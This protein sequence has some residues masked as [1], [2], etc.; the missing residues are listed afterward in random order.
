MLHS[1]G[2]QVGFHVHV[3][4]ILTGGGLSLDKDAGQQRW[5]EIPRDHPALQAE[6]LSVIF[7]RL[8]LRRLKEAL[9]R[10]K[11]QWPE[12]LLAGVVLPVANKSD[13][14]IHNISTDADID[15]ATEEPSPP[16]KKQTLRV[17]T[18]DELDLL[19][20]LGR[21]AYSQHRAASRI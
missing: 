18:A 12:T 2:Q 3:H 13:N 16:K 8:F 5:I 1:W 4:I 20:V 11:L 9:R 21:A 17:L 15:A 7:K 6:A 14:A 10:N 19:R